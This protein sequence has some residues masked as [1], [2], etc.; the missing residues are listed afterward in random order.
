MCELVKPLSIVIFGSY[1]CAVS[2]LIRMD[3]VDLI[4]ADASPRSGSSF[5][6][7]TRC[8]PLTFLAGFNPVRKTFFRQ[9]VFDQSWPWKTTWQFAR[10][11]ISQQV[12]NPF[13][14]PTVI[15]RVGLLWHI[16]C[17]KEVGLNCSKM[18]VNEFMGQ[19]E[20]P[21][22]DVIKRGWFDSSFFASFSGLETLFFRGLS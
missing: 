14:W 16:K 6:W 21:P 8:D 5:L 4:V 18:A 1:R 7:R 9:F 19:I 20:P 2:V 22:I 12:K 13:S 17:R 15:W 3:Y 10:S 11:D